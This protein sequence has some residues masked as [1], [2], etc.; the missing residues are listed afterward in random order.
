MD[1]PCANIGTHTVFTQQTE[2]IRETM[3]K[4]TGSVF[5]LYIEDLEKLIKTQL[6][7]HHQI[8]V[9]GDFNSDL[10]SRNNKMTE[11]MGRNN[12]HNTIK[13]RHGRP[14]STYEYGERPLDGIFCSDTIGIQAG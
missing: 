9:M 5:E 6:T 2:K 11:M 8:V 1:Y 10:N 4:Y 7:K 3:P 14:T 12:I 13:G